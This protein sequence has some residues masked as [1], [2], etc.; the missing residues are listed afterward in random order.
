M[1]RANFRRSPLIS[2]QLTA[3][4]PSPS[5]RR[6]L[7]FS[8]SPSSPSAHSR[9]VPS[10]PLPPNFS[11]LGR[12]FTTALQHAAK[13]SEALPR[14]TSDEKEVS[15]LTNSPG[16]QDTTPYKE[17]LIYVATATR[18]LTIID[19]SGKCS[20]QISKFVKDSL[21]DLLDAIHHVVMFINVSLKQSPP[22]YTKEKPFGAKRMKEIF[23]SLNF[24]L[25]QIIFCHG[26]NPFP[27]SL[28][29]LHPNS[30]QIKSIC[31][32]MFE[33][34]SST[35]NKDFV[36]HCGLNHTFDN[37]N[38][39]FGSPLTL[40]RYS[41]ISSSGTNA[42]TSPTQTLPPQTQLV[43]SHTQS[44]SRTELA[45]ISHGVTFFCDK[46]CK[47]MK[48]L[49]SIPIALDTNCSCKVMKGDPI[50]GTL[51]LERCLRNHPS[52]LFLYI[53][54]YSPPSSYE[55]MITLKLNDPEYLAYRAIPS[56]I[57]S[58][59][60]LKVLPKLKVYPS[61][62]NNLAFIAANLV[63]LRGR[64]LG[65][66]G[67]DD[68]SPSS[69][70]LPLPHLS[71]KWTNP[72]DPAF[73]FEILSQLGS[74]GL[75]AKVVSSDENSLKE[76]PRLRL[77]IIKTVVAA[78]QSALQN[79][80]LCETLLPKFLY[81]PRAE[82]FKSYFPAIAEYKTRGQIA[83]CKPPRIVTAI[84]YL[85]CA[86]FAEDEGPIR[87]YLQGAIPPLLATNG[88]ILL[89]H[90]FAPY[91]DDY[92]ETLHSPRRKSSKRAKTRDSGASS[93][94][95]T[96]RPGTPEPREVI[97][98][99]YRLYD[100]LLAKYSPLACPDVTYGASLLSN[101]ASA[102][103]QTTGASMTSTLTSTPNNPD[104]T[105]S[106]LSALAVLGS[107]C[108]SSGPLDR[109][110][111]K[112]LPILFESSFMHI[113][114]FWLEEDLEIYS[115]KTIMTVHQS[116][117]F[118]ELF[119]AKRLPDNCSL[120]VLVVRE[121]LLAFEGDTENQFF[122]LHAFLEEF[123]Y[124]PL[125][126]SL[127]DKVKYLNNATMHLYPGFVVEE[128]APCMKRWSKYVYRLS[129]VENSTGES[130]EIFH[131]ILVK[132]N[133]QYITAKVLLLFERGP[134]VFLLRNVLND[135]HTLQSIMKTHARIILK[136]LLESLGQ[137]EKQQD[138][139]KKIKWS[140]IWYNMAHRKS[141]KGNRENT[142]QQSNASS[143]RPLESVDMMI[144]MTNNPDGSSNVDVASRPTVSNDE[145]EEAA[146][147]WVKPHIMFLLHNFMLGYKNK[148]TEQKTRTMCCINGIIRFL[149]PSE[150]ARYMPK[151][152]SSVN[153]GLSDGSNDPK[154]RF[155][156]LKNL[157]SFVKVLC[158]GEIASVC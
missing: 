65:T 35:P 154:L 58:H 127:Q 130:M 85:L 56:L 93:L 36:A 150:A 61:I 23:T 66:Y 105:T 50:M 60:G 122:F 144:N 14:A 120:F 125:S 129:R 29:P 152:L 30:R 106:K 86:P 12:L 77:I 145:Q 138:V 53:S 92:E 90:L 112:I 107:L 16:D 134:I 79:S 96:S 15:F 108:I 75:L 109:T 2:S 117:N 67:V 42:T 98:F 51:N 28:H 95:K 141:S 8:Q 114:K 55:G 135:S 32:H 3:M 126:F 63:G 118:T 31:T 80:E 10:N 128:D 89:S 6:R 39:Q 148:D 123:I 45:Q 5:K 46:T 70:I 119:S 139:L 146:R 49:F 102:S 40:N 27:S 7:D 76:Y 153:I 115:F 62:K 52:V 19:W 81:P 143:I 155:Y 72:A 132:K 103:V 149:V 101:T 18:I 156:A 57:F 137:I 113:L 69:S 1:V 142:S 11:S 78:L 43:L 116:I 91:D 82:I 94:P 136:I 13:L 41:S 34:F 104:I 21:G 158:Q 24:A 74:C 133:I 54:A 20:R 140:A 37:F 97:T 111:S 83:S 9:V 17:K 26:R 87:D 4:S 64:I 48:E 84:L 131:L 100:F 68:D 99:F 38:T 73:S 121:L 88:G 71:E 47:R 157:V 33:I 22:D 59:G 25:T 147:L 124:K 151:I 110:S 44:P